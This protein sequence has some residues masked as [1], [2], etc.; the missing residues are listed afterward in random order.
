MTPQNLA[1]SA[2]S[3]SGR[4]QRRRQARHRAAGHDTRRAAAS[5]NV[6]TTAS[7]CSAGAC[8]GTAN[9]SAGTP[10]PN[11]NFC[12]G[13]ETCNGSGSCVDNTDP[14]PGH[15]TGDVCNDSCNEAADD[16]TANDSAHPCNDANSERFIDDEQEGAI[17]RASA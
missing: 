13:A 7:A 12:D 11:A 16:C 6:C 8:V 2:G 1:E 17:W 15:N 14:C 5:F 9:A 10:C 3:R 4:A